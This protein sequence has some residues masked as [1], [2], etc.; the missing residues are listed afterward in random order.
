MLFRSDPG[1]RHVVVAGDVTASERLDQVTVRV[2]HLRSLVRPIAP[3]SDL[4]ATVGVA[5]IIRRLQPTVVVTHQS[6]GGV[7]GRLAARLARLRGPVVA[8]LSMSA[9]DEVG[10]GLQR[11]LSTALERR[12]ASM[13]DLYLCV[14][15]DLASQYISRARVPADRVQV[16]R[17]SLQLEAFLAGSRRAAR[18]SCGLG[19]IPTVAYVG[20]FEER[21]G[22]AELPAMLAAVQR[23]IGSI[24]AILV[25]DGP[26]RS[27]VVAEIDRIPGI[28]G[29]APGHTPDVAT[30]MLAADV[31][32]LPSR[33]E[34]LPQVL[35]Q[36][37]AAGLPFVAYDVCGVRELLGLGAR[38][39]CVPRGDVSAMA[40]ALIG[41]L[42]AGRPRRRMDRS[43]LAPWDADGV[44][45]SHREW[46][47]RATAT[48]TATSNGIDQ[49]GEH[50]GSNFP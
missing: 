18:A 2:V 46:L 15:S 6:K 38:G 45:A 34:G 37:A 27:T 1:G 48:A 23:A 9:F 21:K 24:T 28:V 32:C 13:T 16:V 25:G 29:R 35:V 5:R 40:N 19:D 12:L 4:R 47:E 41:E 7:I 44:G 30:Y 10:G 22:V 42:Q 49:R 8:S 17:S 26:L 39:T 43:T 33:S 14:G 11:R 36:A 50:G 3:V 31:L 20:S